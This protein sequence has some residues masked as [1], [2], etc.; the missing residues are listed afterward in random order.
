MYVC[1]SLGCSLISPLRCAGEKNNGWTPHRTRNET[2]EEVAAGLII[3]VT[4]TS[5]HRLV[6]YPTTSVV[7][8]CVF[9]ECGSIVVFGCEFRLHLGN[10]VAS[11]TLYRMAKSIWLLR[12]NRRRNRTVQPTV[13]AKPETGRRSWC[14]RRALI[15]ITNYRGYKNRFKSDNLM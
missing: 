14:L 4:K 11:V 7:C 13:R 1:V 5:R 15:R 12:V 9:V 6:F 10:R 3:E 2:V 8:E